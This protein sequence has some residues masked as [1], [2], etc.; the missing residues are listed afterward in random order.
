MTK[1]AGGVGG[2]TSYAEIALGIILRDAPEAAETLGK[3]M[4][5]PPRNAA[6][7]LSAAKAILEFAGIGSAEADK[8]H[9]ELL[10][11]LRGK[12]SDVA[13]AEVIRAL[14]SL[15]HVRGASAGGDRGKTAH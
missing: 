1:D 3:L 12:V 11:A 6:I 9:T 15:Q 5:D 2:E 14:T 7:A 13:Y 4:R 8:K 10:Q